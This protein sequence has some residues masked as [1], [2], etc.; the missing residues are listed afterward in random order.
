MLHCVQST[1]VS[2]VTINGHR[3]VGI[4]IPLLSAQTVSFWSYNQHYSSCVASMRLH[5]SWI[6]LPCAGWGLAGYLEAQYDYADSAQSP[7]VTLNHLHFVCV[8]APTSL[9]PA[10]ARSSEVFWLWLFAR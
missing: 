7:K 9:A 5:L 4:R 10:L 1:P 2:L 3:I 6:G 8:L